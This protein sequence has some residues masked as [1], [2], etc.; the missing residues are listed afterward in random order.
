M[1]V[2]IRKRASEAPAVVSVKHLAA[3]AV[4]PSTIND[5]RRAGRAI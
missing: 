4:L 5:G 3:Q 2:C 1:I